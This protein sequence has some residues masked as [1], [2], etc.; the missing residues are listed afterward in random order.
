MIPNEHDQDI[1]ADVQAV[2]RDIAKIL[3]RYGVKPPLRLQAW[4]EIH[5]IIR[6]ALT[7][8]MCAPDA[9]AEKIVRD[10]QNLCTAHGYTVAHTQGLV[11]KIS[12][13]L[14]ATGTIMT[15]SPDVHIL[16][17]ADLSAIKKHSFHRGVERGRFERGMEE[18]FSTAMEIIRLGCGLFF[19][20]NGDG[21]HMSS[22]EYRQAHLEWFERAGNFVREQDGKRAVTS[23]KGT[24]P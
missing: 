17:D 1:E 20:R 2:G 4:D 16:T 24:E 23:T 22:D 9:I 10:Y 14:A 11:H 12:A 18:P 19:G 5:G 8:S 15:I 3:D 7:P 13:A 6:A 21:S